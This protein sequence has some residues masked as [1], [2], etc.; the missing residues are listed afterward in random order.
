MPDPPPPPK[1]K[2]PGTDVLGV[3]D[4]VQPKEPTEEPK[5]AVT[6]RDQ[7]SGVRPDIPRPATGPS[8]DTAVDIV[9]EAST[10]SSSRDS[11]LSWRIDTTPPEGCR[12]PLLTGDLLRQFK[13][14]QS[15]LEA[16]KSPQRE[17]QTRGIV[18]FRIQ[19]A[20]NDPPLPEETVKKL[21]RCLERLP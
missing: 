21:A 16:V 2:R 13:E 11:Y 1:D 12:G 18:H 8:V 17:T 3:D 5:E 14:I 4:D 6:P 15:R 20:P 19:N 10:S 7:D 9:P